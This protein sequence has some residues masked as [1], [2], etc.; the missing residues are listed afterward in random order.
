MIY[1]FPPTIDSWGDKLQGMELRDYFAARAIGAIMSTVKHE[2]ERGGLHSM[3]LDWYDWHANHAYA[4]A[5]A[6][7]KARKE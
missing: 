5:D 1:A 7:M 6:M 2:D 3:S 4:I